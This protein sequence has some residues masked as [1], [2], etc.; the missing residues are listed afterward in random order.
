MLRMLK[1]VILGKQ[2]EQQEAGSGPLEVLQ[3][4]WDELPHVLWGTS[5]GLEQRG[6][7]ESDH[8]RE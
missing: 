7:L 3:S 5:R 6:E 1:L 4:T 8:L 2:S